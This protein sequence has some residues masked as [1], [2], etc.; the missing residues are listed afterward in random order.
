MTVVKGNLTDLE[1]FVTNSRSNA[2][3]LEEAVLDRRSKVMSFANQSGSRVGPDGLTAVGSASDGVVSELRE[4]ADYV[5]LFADAVVR[6]DVLGEDGSFE[7]DSVV[8]EDHMRDIAHERGQSFDD[9]TT[10]DAAAEF[11]LP[12]VGTVPADSGWVGDPVATATGHFIVTERDIPMPARLDALE[13]PRTYA[14]IAADVDS[15]LGGGWCSWLNAGCTVGASSISVSDQNGREVTLHPTDAP[16]PSL[17]AG[18]ATHSSSDGSVTAILDLDADAHLIVAW[19][20]RSDRVGQIWT[21]DASDRLVSVA[22]E[23]IGVTRFGYVA[24]RLMTLAHDGGRRL[25]LRWEGDLLAG[26]EAS[27][28]RDVEYEYEDG[29]LV[30]VDA[31]GSRQRYGYTDGRVSAVVDA[32]GVTLVELTYDAHGRVVTQRE[33]MGGA[34]TFEYEGATTFVGTEDGE[35]RAA[36]KHDD[37]GRVIAAGGSPLDPLTRRFD[38]AGRTIHQSNPD[39]TGFEMSVESSP[40]DAA[41]PSVRETI[42]HSGG[43]IETYDYDPYDRLTAHHCDDRWVTYRYDGTSALPDRVEAPDGWFVDI[44]W[45]NGLPVSI[46]DADGVESRFDY[47][48]DGNL[49]AA[50]DGLANTTRYEHHASG[51]RTRIIHSDGAEERF[52]LDDAGRMLEFV[53]ANGA[54]ATFELTPAA[55]L[56]SATDPIGNVTRV[57]HTGGVPTGFV[58]AAGSRYGWRVDADGR[59]QSVTLPDGSTRAFVRDDAGRLTAL[60]ASEAGAV[61]WIRRWEIDPEARPSADPAERADAPATNDGTV[62]TPAGRLARFESETGTVEFEYDARG[63]IVRRGHGDRWWTFERDSRGR[64]L[65]VVSPMGRRQR[66]D[67]DAV[68]RV[69]SD[70]LGGATSEH[71]YDG[72]GRLVRSRRNGLVSEYRYG[73]LGE[74]VESVDA[75]GGSTRYTYDERRR[76]VEV[77]DALGSITQVAYAFDDQPSVVTDALGRTRRFVYDDGILVESIDEEGVTSYDHDA[78]GKVVAIARAERSGGLDEVRIVHDDRGQIVAVQ[79]DDRRIDLSDVHERVVDGRIMLDRDGLSS[80]VSADGVRRSIERDA[81]G[82]RRTIVDVIDGITYT[83]SLER[84]A[85]GAVVADGGERG[86]RSFEYLESGF[87]GAVTGVDHGRFEYDLLGRLVTERGASADRHYSYDAAH[88]LVSIDDA[89]RETRFAYDGIG[90]RTSATGVRSVDYEWDGWGLTG[91]VTSRGRTTIRRNAIG[92][93]DRVTAPDGRVTDVEW[94]AHAAFPRPVRIGDD[95]IVHDGANVVALRSPSGVRP[96]PDLQGVWGEVDVEPGDVTWHPFHGLYVDGHVVLGQ[97]VYDIDTRQFLSPDP[98]RP[99]VGTA[100]SQWAYCYAANDPV[101]RLDPLG[102]SPLSIDEFERLKDRY[103]GTQW[104]NIASV[105]IVVAAVVLTPTGA[106]PLV[107]VAAGAATGLASE[108][109]RQL[110]NNATNRGDE[111]YDVGA[112]VKSTVLGAATGPIAIPGVSETSRFATTV[113]GRAVVA[114]TEGAAGGTV[115]ELYDLTPLPGSDGSFDVDQVVISAGTSVVAGEASHQ[116]RPPAPAVVA[117]SPTPV[118]PSTP[119]PT[120]G[121]PTAVAPAAPVAAAPSPGVA[122]PQPPSGGATAPQPAAPPASQVAPAPQAAPASPPAPAPAPPPAAPQP[123]PVTRPVSP[124]DPS[125]PIMGNRDSM[126]FHTPSSQYYDI[127]IP[128]EWFATVDEAV[129]AGYRAPR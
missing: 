94:D 55:R 43:S 58:D 47:D 65:A 61:P 25:T 57:E 122:G 126:I 50:I 70:E 24:D 64:I 74:L 66:Y 52:T 31:P 111:G 56:V 19:G 15:G 127:T 45:A 8:L 62:F 28:G 26:I 33:Y 79:R 125:R 34:T 87:L 104:G 120:V 9:L 10:V 108:G 21:F 22:G 40:S 118:A 42:R 67:L 53:D 81:V 3:S 90:R 30:G 60:V 23:A 102:L 123:A 100:S 117:T 59:A 20:R 98:L 97:R 85:G 112:I 101:N 72:L 49:T 89:G 14:S 46:T 41:P 121:A 36:Y 107:L 115:S 16:P 35:R 44:G 110:V 105:A 4:L 83:R 116:L 114:A 27:D 129:D 106:G 63:M 99:I 29:R 73:P 69:I 78:T 95:T 93:V 71:D 37:V 82:R 86:R 103:T 5:E 6:A 12:E 38:D 92:L 1:S 119:N 75:A 18:D 2:D 80:G 13:W 84:D 109:G 39:Q 54:V 17:L 11:T 124:P 128:E 91:I 32:D 68:G 51:G 7:V 96:L 48:D 88:Q 77:D 76:V 113:G